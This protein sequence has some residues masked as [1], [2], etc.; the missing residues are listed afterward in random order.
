VRLRALWPPGQLIALL[1]GITRVPGNKN[2]APDSDAL[3]GAAGSGSSSGGSGGSGGAA[4]ESKE[5][6]ASGGSGASAEW[7]GKVGGTAGKQSKLLREMLAL[8]EIGTTHLLMM[9]TESEFQVF[10]SACCLASNCSIR[11]QIWTLFVALAGDRCGPQQAARVR[12]AAG[13][14]GHFHAHGLGTAA[15]SFQLTHRL[16]FLPS[17]SIAW[18][19]GCV[20]CGRQMAH[21]IPLVEAAVKALTE[22]ADNKYVRLCLASCPCHSALNLRV[23]AACRVIV[24][25]KTGFH[26]AVRLL[27]LRTSLRWA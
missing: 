11:S 8:K 24:I 5:S 23:A 15:G 6:K 9:V 16:Q 25:S 2:F 21:A 14:Q 3:F 20:V 1:Q 4:T 27:A 19:H 22:D 26:R 18:V 10:G 7:L 17:F 12:Q 13:H